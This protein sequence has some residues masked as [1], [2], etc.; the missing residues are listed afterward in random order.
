MGIPWVTAA[1]VRERAPIPEGVQ[2]DALDRAIAQAS[3]FLAGLSTVRPSEARKVIPR[4]CPCAL[5]LLTGPWPSSAGSFWWLVSGDELALGG[6]ACHADLILPDRPVLTIDTVTVAGTVMDADLYELRGD[7]RLH[8]LDGTHW[9]AQTVV[10]YTTGSNIDEGAKLAVSRL[11]MELAKL[12]MPDG[13]CGL[14]ERVQTVVR[15][16]VTF[17]LLDPQTFLD[18]GR[19]GIYIVDLFLT[20]QHHLAQ[21]PSSSVVSPGIGPELDYLRST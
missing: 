1:E 4:P 13:K 6:G 11:A 21:G 10:D 2:N 5:D 15:N 19:T 3:D 20:A 16:G 7:N 9:T 14:P 18:G 12:A 17:A 8:R